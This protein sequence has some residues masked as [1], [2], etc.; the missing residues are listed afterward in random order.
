M[1]Q[2]GEIIKI[3][4]KRAWIKYTSPGAACGNC[5]GCMHLSNKGS[6]KD[7][8]IE[9]D[10]NIAA[11]VGDAIIV[12]YPTEVMLK[13]MLVLY[14]VPFVGLFLGYFLTYVLSNNELISGIVAGIGLVV[15]GLLTRP[16]AKAVTN[17]NEK[18]RIVAK[19]C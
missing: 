5:K 16:I 7:R 2:I 12:E 11:D 13:G 10:M 8:V 6:K 9:V 1:R 4:D 18:P 14:G 17:K 19:A 3:E 15:F